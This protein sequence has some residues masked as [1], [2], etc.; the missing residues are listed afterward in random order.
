MTASSKG[1]AGPAGC[2]EM[3]KRDVYAIIF[4]SVCI[5]AGVLWLMIRLIDSYAF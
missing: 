2:I 5:G 1:D 3:P 4:V